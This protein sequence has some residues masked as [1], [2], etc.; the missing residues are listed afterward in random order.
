MLPNSVFL[1]KLKGKIAGEE[2]GNL[3]KLEEMARTE[4]QY[5]PLSH[6]GGMVSV[7]TTWASKTPR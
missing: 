1:S 5:A 6:M 4:A 7:L 3:V 2:Q